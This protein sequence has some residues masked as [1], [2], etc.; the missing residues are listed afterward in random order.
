MEILL[1]ICKASLAWTSFDL[2]IEKHTVLFKKRI[3]KSVKFKE[4]IS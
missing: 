1:W 2:V 3:K 4:M